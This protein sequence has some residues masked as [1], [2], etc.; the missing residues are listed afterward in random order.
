LSGAGGSSQ[1]GSG[2]SS[3]GAATG[4]AGTSGGS[5][6]NSSGLIPRRA[7]RGDTNSQGSNP[8]APKPKPE[9]SNMQP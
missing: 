3:G 8:N 7:D 6:A 9:T 4:G 2:S 1:T 5:D